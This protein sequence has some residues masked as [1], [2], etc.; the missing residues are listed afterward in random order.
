MIIFSKSGIHIDRKKQLGASSLK[1]INVDSQTLKIQNVDIVHCPGIEI[2]QT[3]SNTLE[4]KL[5]MT[6]ATDGA[7]VFLMTTKLLYIDKFF[8][9]HTDY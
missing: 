6:S 9:V 8:G 2:K 3:I 5:S 4:K 7:P 1:A